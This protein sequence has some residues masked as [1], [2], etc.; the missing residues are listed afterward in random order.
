MITIQDI[1]L[2]LETYKGTI[3][4][5]PLWGLPSET[6]GIIRQF[7][8]EAEAPTNFIYSNMIA[9]VA[10]VVARKMRIIDGNYINRPI[11]YVANVGNSGC[12]KTPARSIVKSSVGKIEEG[13]YESY[14]TE[15][16]QWEQTDNKRK[17]E[18]PIR[19]RLLLENSDTSMEKFL[20]ILDENTKK[21]NLNGNGILLNLDELTDFFPNLNRYSGRD[22]NPLAKFLMLYNCENIA[23]DRLGRE[24]QY[25]IE[26]TCVIVGGI[27]PDRLKMVFGGEYGSG[28]IPRWL[29]LMENKACKWIQPNQM[30]H[31][32]WD[33]ILQRGLEMLPIDLYFSPEAEKELHKNHEIR[34][35]QNLL[36][37]DRAK[38]L[39]EYIVKQNYTVRRL[40]GIIHTANALAMRK[41]VKPEI[42][43]DEYRY[44]ESVVDYLI[45]SASV[46]LL[47]L[48]GKM[49]LQPYDLTLEETFVQLFKHIPDTNISLLAKATGKDRS[50]IHRAKRKYVQSLPDEK[51]VVALSWFQDLEEEFPRVFKIAGGMPDEIT[52][53]ALLATCQDNV[54]KFYGI[55]KKM[56]ESPDLEK[57]TPEEIWLSGWAEHLCCF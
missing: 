41:E 10:S 43:V 40:A 37:R 29:F 1:K 25:I 36:L 18:K 52:L 47:M 42:D 5:I 49:P 8:G 53:T 4:E 17:D 56:E 24:D 15:L 34:R 19:N 12:G 31:Q 23:V 33:N 26:P 38:E 46:F 45:K 11:L 55:L 54:E 39:G 35:E 28:F 9:S 21:N 2:F 3:D 57:Y 50:N 30:Y 32:Y 44:A 51:K 6:V 27:Q 16:R 48:S 7:S 20:V 14:T 22:G 13:Y